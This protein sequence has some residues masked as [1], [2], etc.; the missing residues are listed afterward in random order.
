MKL[1]K[2]FAGDVFGGVRS[3][4]LA[5][6]VGEKNAIMDS[7][8]FV[9]GET[10]I[11]Q[12]IDTSDHNNAASTIVDMAAIGAPG[13]DVTTCKTWNERLVAVATQGSGGKQD[14][15]CCTRSAPRESSPSNESS[16][17]QWGGCLTRS[18]GPRTAGLSL[19]LARE[20][21]CPF[22]HRVV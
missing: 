10:S 6:N 7:F 11:L 14:P 9:V 13:T 20:R 8:V 12:V 19:R 1:P 15:G 5:A 3:F 17:Q 2:A 18:S 22:R 16:R 4:E 21:L